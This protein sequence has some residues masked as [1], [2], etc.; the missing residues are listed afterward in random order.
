MQ[1]IL[2]IIGLLI[3]IG[4]FLDFFHTTISGNGFGILSATVNTQLSKL[5]LRDKSRLSFRYSGL[6]HVMVTTMTWLFLM[7]LGLYLILISSD[8]M[9]IH[10]ESEVAASYVERF[11]YMCYV[12]STLG[13]GD[14]VPGNDM[15][16]VFTG[17]FSFLGLILLTTALT[18]FLSVIKAVLQKKQLALFISAMGT[19]ISELYQFL[20]SEDNTELLT[21][22]SR[23]LK[24]MIIQASSNYIFFPIIQYYLTKKKRA[25]AELQL[26]RLNEVLLV[27]QNDFPEESFDHKR[28]LSLRKSITY[29]L[30]LGLENQQDFKSKKEE[31]QRFRNF[32][33]PYQQTYRAEPEHD[34]SMYAAIKGA[35]WTWAD[36]YSLV[37][38]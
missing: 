25:S 32:W 17:I 10:M 1:I 31:L 5:I 26:A 27:V 13:N 2:I 33:I 20:A 6:I 36:V 18:Y 24:M 9:V 35:G 34:H 4:A 21:E 23:Q 12:V 3:L 19:N 8:Q 11:Y 38:Q 37:D 30:D 22:N 7:L 28:I 29:Y 15:S 14:F 16:R